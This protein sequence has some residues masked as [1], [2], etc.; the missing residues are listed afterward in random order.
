MAYPAKEEAALLARA[1]VDGPAQGDEGNSPS[2][3]DT[4]DAGGFT[5]PAW[6]L[7]PIADHLRRPA[8]VELPEG[9]RPS[10][11]AMDRDRRGAAAL[12]LPQCEEVLAKRLAAAL[13]EDEA[14]TS[15]TSAALEQGR[16]LPRRQAYL[17]KGK[18]G[19]WA[20]Y[21]EGRARVRCVLAIVSPGTGAPDPRSAREVVAAL[22]EVLAVDS[23]APEETAAS[24]VGD[25]PTRKRSKRG[26]N[27]PPD[28]SAH[29]YVPQVG[30]TKSRFGLAMGPCRLL[31][32]GSLY[33]RDTPDQREDCAP[34]LRLVR[35]KRKPTTDFLAQYFIGR[36]VTSIASMRWAVVL[37]SLS[38]AEYKTTSLAT[39]A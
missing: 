18:A 22:S 25:R 23:P 37:T 28:A 2:G 29:R 38:H 15:P 1:C 17:L 26:P 13:G 30:V 8:L 32:R 12:F 31:Q 24:A 20:S 5:G 16:R 11:V 9:A 39:S 7:E 33:G 4:F 36:Y 3:A 6:A 27:H 10:E 34:S 14:D 19:E 35:L 21:D